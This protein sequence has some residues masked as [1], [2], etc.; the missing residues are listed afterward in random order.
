MKAQKENKVE[1]VEKLLGM[2]LT[3]DDSLKKYKS[4]EYES[5]KLKKLREQIA[6]EFLTKR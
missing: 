3:L 6:G 1:V 5:P 2:T 4:P